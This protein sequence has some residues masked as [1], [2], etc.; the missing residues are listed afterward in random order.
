MGQQ[1]KAYYLIMAFALTAAVSWAARGAYE[2]YLE[3]GKVK[4]SYGYLYEAIACIN[5]YV[6]EKGALPS[7]IEQALAFEWSNVKDHDISWPS[8]IGLRYYPLLYQN[9]RYIYCLLVDFGNAP[10]KTMAL[11]IVSISKRG[12][13]ELVEKTLIHAEGEDYTRR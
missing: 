11:A 4:G 10:A 6:R 7:S 2:R 12:D 9:D 8:K 1:R 5:I 13:G 3:Y